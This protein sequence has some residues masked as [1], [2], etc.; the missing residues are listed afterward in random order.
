MGASTG[1]SASPPYGKRRYV[2]LGTVTLK[3]AEAELR[4]VLADGERGTWQA[5]VKVEPEP[6]PVQLPTFHQNAELWWERNVERP[7]GPLLK[8]PKTVEDYR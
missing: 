6:E 1:P 4:H 5:P 2:S 7:D 8:R 3:A